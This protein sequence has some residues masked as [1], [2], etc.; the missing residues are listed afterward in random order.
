MTTQPPTQEDT[1]AARLISWLRDFAATRL[2]SRI[3]DERRCIPP[4]VLMDFANA[5]LF[6]INTPR[7][8]GGLG[9]NR[10]Q[11]IAALEQLGAIDLCLG[12]VVVNNN[13]LGIHP[14]IHHAR[15]E[16]RQ[17]WLPHFAA[18]RRLVSY[19]LTEPAA[20]SNPMGIAG[21]AVPDGPGHWRITATKLWIGSAAWARAINVFVQLDEP[22]RRGMTGFFVPSDLPGFNMG[23]ELLTMGV[24]GM[25][26]NRIHIRD[27]RVSEA[28]LL[29]RLGEG[30]TVAHDAMMITRLAFGAA[31]LGG[32]KRCAQLMLRYASR[33]DISTGRLLDNPV[34]LVRMDETIAKIELL[35]ALVSQVAHRSDAGRE[36][37]EE[38]LVVCKTAGSE[39]L[40]QATDDLVQ[41]LGGRGYLENNFAP[42]L[43]RDARVTRIFEGPTETLHAY[44]GSKMLKK[45]TNLPEFWQTHS[46]GVDLAEKMRE[47]CDEVRSRLQRHEY[48]SLLWA[49]VQVGEALFWGILLS[50]AR[51]KA[52]SDNGCHL[53]RAVRWA[54]RRFQ[55]VVQ[56]ILD[57]DVQALGLSDG[58]A[59]SDAV[60]G[61]RAAIDDLVQ[62][63]PGED[64]AIDPLLRKQRP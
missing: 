15:D 17:Q 13:F 48:P 11:I 34:T 49:N 56:L 6:G 53:A 54:E 51:T 44:L 5:G 27:V 35:D 36:V 42:Q 20:G 40:W 45:S 25:V 37:P 7:S 19:A 2:N 41:L 4:H 52:A 28:N 58:D 38:L 9:L 63:L 26:Q 18:G 62:T 3:I 60:E 8:F 57:G 14:V 23:E 10:T 16:I 29:G 50:A 55:Q 12:T 43:M 1:T 24:R 47:T 33:R 21:R 59:V 64:W 46:N 22:G 30:M 31:F 32:M 39:F 61:Y